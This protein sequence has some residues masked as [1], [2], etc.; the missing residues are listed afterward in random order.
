[1]T[2][3]PEGAASRWRLIVGAPL[4]VLLITSLDQTI[5]STALPTTVGIVS[6][7]TA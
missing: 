4:L 1:V 7:C 6:G 5:V 3:V 2:T